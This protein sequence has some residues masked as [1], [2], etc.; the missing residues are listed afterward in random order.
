MQK[1]AVW[2]EC[3]R[4]ASYFAPRGKPR[5]LMLGNL[6]GQRYL[7][8]YDK[9]IGIIGE[10]GIGK[11]SVIRGMFP[12]LELSNDDE[13]VNNRSASLVNVVQENRFSYFTYHMDY[14][15]EMAFSQPYEIADAV[16]IALKNNRRIVIEHFDLLHPILKINAHCLIG[17]GEEIV[18]ARPNIFGPF[19]QD[20]KNKIA[21]TALIRRMAHSAEDITCMVLQREFGI[22]PPSFHSDIF[23]GFVVEFKDVPKDL[24]LSLIEAMVIEI[25]AKNVEIG[26]KDESHIQIGEELFVCTGPRIHVKRS[27]DIQNFRLNKSFIFDEMNDVYCLVGQVGFEMKTIL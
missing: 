19:P 8:T 3:L 18:V 9:L 10:P 1:N 26:Y 11:S 14:Q 23:H 4:V 16:K 24:D 13:R 27:G 2:H 25:I 6:L 5:L 21:G 7:T 12:G 15:F 17:I 20:I 22:Q